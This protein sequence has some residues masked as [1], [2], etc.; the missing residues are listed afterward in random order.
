MIST[1]DIP[2][3]FARKED[4]NLEDFV[5]L[6]Y[7]FETSID[8]KLAAAALCSEQSTA[9]WK[10]PGYD[11]DFR[12][13]YGAKVIS[14][15]PHEDPTLRIEGDKKWYHLVIAHPHH[16]FGARIPNLLS[17]AA[18]EGAFYCPGVDRIKWIDLECPA[19]Y[20]K[21][22]EGPRFG[23][24]GLREQLQIF[25]RPLFIGVVKPN[26]GLDPQ[27]FANIAYESWIGGLDIAKDD[28]M[29]G[30]MTWSP[31]QVRAQKCGEARKKAE[32][33]AQT[34]K[35]Y[36]ASITDEVDQIASLHDVAVQE[37]ANAVMVNGIFTGIS[38]VRALRR[39]THVPMMSHFT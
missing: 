3:F 34:P 33:L 5:L 15:H 17:A 25:D 21:Q 9:Q 1:Q 19:S 4:L 20:L 16:N 26:I 29:L 35:I 27:T 36:L 13:L 23:L 12:E 18:G 6:T 14:L 24:K 32:A 10:R 8:P 28:E 31:L 30:D 2:G 39:Q 37:G 11:E 38:A 22:F 7:I